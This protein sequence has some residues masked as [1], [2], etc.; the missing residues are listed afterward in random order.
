MASTDGAA[1]GGRA[2]RQSRFVAPPGACQLLVVRHGESAPYVEG[3]PHPL[4]D[5]QGDPPL[6]PVGRAQAE[7]VADRLISTGERIDA[8]YVTSMQR[9]H[10]TAAPLAARLGIE[11]RVE[12]RLREVHLGDWEG[13]EFRKRVAD[14]DPIAVEMLTLGRWDVIPGAEPHD[15]F[16]GR[17]VAGAEAI[18]AAH[19]DEVVVAVLHGGV[20]GQLLAHATGAKSFA[21]SGADNASITHLVIG[22]HGWAV[23]CFNDTSHLS[24][25]FTVAPEPPG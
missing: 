11:P 7:L 15:V 10:Q 9:T 24:P 5:G 16:A 6:D 21:F 12:P 1:G 22:P 8:I 18:A 13:G 3:E 14:R 17:V 19:P 20:I 4:I 2:F 23:R 25:T